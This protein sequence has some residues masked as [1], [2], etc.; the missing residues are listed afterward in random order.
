MGLAMDLLKP[1][2]GHVGVDLRGGEALVT[3]KFLDDAKVR[4]ALDEMGG[5]RVAK[6]V[7]MHVT[8]RDAVDEDPAHVARSQTRTAT[9]EEEGARW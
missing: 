6:R 2:L 4:A 7:R 3:E 9:I 5:V 1:G 8:T